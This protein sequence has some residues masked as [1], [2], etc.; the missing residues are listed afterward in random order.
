MIERLPSFVEDPRL[1]ALIAAAF[2]LAAAY[3]VARLVSWL[4]GRVLVRAARRTVTAR[5][6]R[7]VDS[8]KRSLTRSIFLFG[9]MAA[10]VTL[11]VSE[12]AQ[13]RILQAVVA[14]WIV[15]TTLTLIRAW[16]LG[17]AWTGHERDGT[18]KAWAKDF[19]PL[20]TKVGAVVLGIFGL[21]G[22]LESFGVDVN[23][24]VVSLGVGSLA[25]GLAAP[26]TLANM[27]AGFTLMLDRPFLIG[28]R[29][30]LASG[31]TGDVVEIGIRATRIQTPD[32]TILVV[33]NGVLTK[34]KV[35]NLTRPTRSLTARAEVGVVY[36][37]DLDKAKR[38]LVDAARASSYVDKEREPVVLVTRLADFSINLRV[39]FWVRDYLE[40]GLALSG[41]LEGIVRGLGEAGIEIAL[42][43]QRVVTRQSS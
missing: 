4:V 29:I 13:A 41:V 6:D 8:L 33:P 34:E 20:L 15:V 39:A 26:D 17:L 10:A 37:S 27:F 11:P 25:V 19:G 16:K 42:P 21:I 2:L 28:D 22:L 14:L 36:G 7:L 1:Q 32:E 24:L 31:E 38:V 9:A 35:T 40:Q 5:D 23:S 12:G 30:Q 43:A 18:A 3:V